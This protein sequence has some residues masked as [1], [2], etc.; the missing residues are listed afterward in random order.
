MDSENTQTQ[1][2]PEKPNII[3]SR[4]DCAVFLKKGQLS[5]TPPVPAE[6][7]PIIRGVSTRRFTGL[8]RKAVWVPVGLGVLAGAA[9]ALTCIQDF[10][11]DIGHIA[12]GSLWFTVAMLCWILGFA[13]TAAMMIPAWRV[14][15]Y[16][17]PDTGLGE[18]FSGFLAAALFGVHA[19]RLVL[20]AFTTAPSSA[21]A[22]NTVG[23]SKLA[24]GFLFLTALYFL[25]VGLGR[26]GIL[27]TVLSMGGCVSVMLVLFRDYFQFDLPL[28]SPVRNLAMLAYAAL[29]LFFLAETRMH[30]DLWYTGVPFTVLAN[31]SV[32]LLTGAYGLAEVILAV[33]G[34]AQFS[35]VE[36]AA[37][38]GTAGLAFFRLK[39]LPLLIGDHLP[40]PPTEEEVKKASKK[41]QK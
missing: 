35:M 20:T 27:L 23:L 41:K 30:V 6:K 12:S 40:P 15:Q 31:A 19:L 4:K 32:I 8:L 1:I 22:F 33:S 24:A 36:G 18:T 2:P 17:F 16:R 26:R 7:L 3:E 25:C 11:W 38:L 21:A 5:E 9:W 37:F 10:D 14:R 28:N 39:K 34:Y 13:G 29:L